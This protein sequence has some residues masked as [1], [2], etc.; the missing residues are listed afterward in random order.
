[1]KTIHKFLTLQASR[2]W[3]GKTENQTVRGSLPETLSPIHL[4][5]HAHFLFD[6]GTFIAYGCTPK[7]IEHIR[8]AV[9][10][11]NYLIFLSF[12]SF[13]K[14]LFSGLAENN[15]VIGKNLTVKE[16]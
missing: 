16:Y 6:F 4:K 8:Y 3:T 14:Q 7:V 9:L 5:Y 10:R 15:G 12:L 2:F 11:Y 13:S 1:M